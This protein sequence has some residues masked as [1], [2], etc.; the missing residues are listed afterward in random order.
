[1]QISQKLD[2][3]NQIISTESNYNITLNSTLK[4]G[5]IITD[6]PD[7]GRCMNALNNNKE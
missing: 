1:M 3:R 5:I 6:A 4:I 7:D 2:F